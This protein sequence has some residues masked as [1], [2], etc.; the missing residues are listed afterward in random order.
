MV[1]HAVIAPKA[2]YKSILVCPACQGQVVMDPVEMRCLD[3]GD[4]YETIPAGDQLDLRLRRSREVVTRYTPAHPGTLIEPDLG[5]PIAPAAAPACAEWDSVALTDAITYGNRLT[6]TL[7]SHFPR[8]ESR[9]AWMLDLGCGDRR[10]E[11]LCRSLTGF[12]YVGIDFDGQEPDLLADA[13][14]LPFRDETFSFILS[15][16]V[17]EH[18]AAPAVAMAEVARVL[19][20]GG[21]F[22]GT[23]AFLEPFHMLSHYHMTHVGLARL[24]DDAGF[25]LVAM[26]ANPEWTGLRA[27]AEMALFPGLGGALQRAMVALPD[28]A[29]DGL[30]ATKR[31]I[32]GRSRGQ[33]I[34]RLSTTGGFRFVARRRAEL[35]AVS[36][37]AAAE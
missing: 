13:H 29:S 28:Y 36:A 9:D 37:I 3:C 35:P 18:L 12:N 33:D 21:S 30:A 17:L 4:V 7:L 10:F 26:E 2:Q 6:R 22:I 16:A 25:D 11:P 15:V 5:A 1:N 31:A 24:L 34:R 8:A 32:K 20:P 14:A 23:V 27:Q 19:K